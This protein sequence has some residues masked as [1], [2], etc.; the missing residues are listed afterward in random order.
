MPWH[1]QALPD[2]AI[3]ETSYIGRL[4]LPELFEAVQETLA[5][6]RQTQKYC[7]LGDCSALEGGH[8]L[9]DLFGMIDQIIA[10]GLAHKLKEAVVLP[11]LPAAQDRVE[12]WELACTNRGLRVKLFTDRAS[13]IDWLTK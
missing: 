13:A 10:S 11:R 8:S 2:Q 9:V 12:F 3:V 4:S 7:L 6:V 5:T 1:V